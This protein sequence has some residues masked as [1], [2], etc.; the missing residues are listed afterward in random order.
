MLRPRHRPCKSRYAAR[1]LKHLMNVWP[2]FAAPGRE[3]VQATFV[4]D[5]ALR[6]EAIV[7]TED[8][9]KFLRW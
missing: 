9:E 5:D 8:G 4:F 3:T 1:V 6:A 7:A 2:P